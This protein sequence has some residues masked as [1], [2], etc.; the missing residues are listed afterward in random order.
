MNKRFY[1]YASGPRSPENGIGGV[2]M[3]FWG[4]NGFCKGTPAKCKTVGNGGGN[5]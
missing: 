2:T 4:R 1:H 5:R 3:P